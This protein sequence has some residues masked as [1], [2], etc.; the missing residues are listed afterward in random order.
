V[1][2][3]VGDQVAAILDEEVGPV[4]QPVV[5]DAIGVGGVEVVDALP[6]RGFVHAAGRP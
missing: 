3:A 1:A 6:Q 5:V 2:P 4:L